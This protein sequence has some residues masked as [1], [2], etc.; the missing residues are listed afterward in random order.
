MAHDIAQ[1]AS[2]E[3]MT[4]WAGSTPWHGLGT[5]V[6][7]LMTTTEALQKAHLDW[8]VVKLPLWYDTAP[9]V[10]NSELDAVPDTYGVFRESE[11]GL[12]PLTRGGKA[13]GR[14]WKPLQNVDAFAFMDEIL[15]SH[16]AAIEVAGALG[17][18]KPYGFWRSCLI[19]LSSTG[20]TQWSNTSLS[21]TSTTVQ[22]Q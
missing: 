8:S 18:G 16:E 12:V 2:G 13:V 20:K 9:E 11:D 6:E 21:Q 17:N 22:V 4:A 10:L 19:L 15:Q 7:G 14:V 5:S 3:Y 1:T